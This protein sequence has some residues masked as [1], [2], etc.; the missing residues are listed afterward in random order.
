MANAKAKVT[1]FEEL[2]KAA[3]G[4]RFAEDM[5]N[6]LSVNSKPMPRGYWNLIISIRDCSLYSKGLKPHRHWKISDVK[7]YFG[8]K[9]SAEEMAETLRNYRDILMPKEE[10]KVEA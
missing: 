7:T 9:G 10:K 4:T 3:E 1:N 8:I 6:M 2:K 5:G